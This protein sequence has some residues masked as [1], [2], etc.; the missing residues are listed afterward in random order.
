MANRLSSKSEVEKV[1][2]QIRTDDDLWHAVQDLAG[3]TIPRV[4]V[5][6][7]HVAPF[8]AFADAYFARHR[9]IVW[10]AS[11]GLAGK[12]VL[13]A[14]LAFMEGIEMGAAVNLLGGSGEQSQRVHGYMTGED[15]NL[16]GTFWGHY[17]AP[18]HLLVDDPTKR[19]TKL[20]NGGR[21]VV[22]QAS[23]RSV[24]GPHPQKLRLDECLAAGTLVSTPEGQFRIEDV[25]AGDIVHGW[26]NGGITQGMVQ[27][28]RRVGARQTLELTLSNGKT[29]ICTPDHELLTNG[30]WDEARSCRQGTILQGIRENV[31]VVAVKEGIRR[32]VYDIT[33]KDI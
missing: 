21:I 12:S 19:E 15:T 30:G 16:P 7:D 14:T 2:S 6:E 1:R 23:Q 28:T 32:D 22:L 26:D 33:V 29:L 27:R 18:R 9:N 4:K 10:H 31:K 11:R 8:T 5:C 24:R 25:Q 20:S 3:I 17:G 13:L